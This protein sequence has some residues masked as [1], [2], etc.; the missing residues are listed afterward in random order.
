MVPKEI[1]NEMPAVL[2]VEDEPMLL[3]VVAET[4]RDAGYQ[5]WEAVNGQDA[6]AILDAQPDIVLL[7][8]DIKMPGMD[9]YQLTE[10]SLAKKPDLRVMMMTGYSQAP[11]PK[12]MADAGI[13]VLQKP[14]DIDRLP[15]RAAEVLGAPKLI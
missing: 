6:L 4:L 12:K 1:P 7:L 15:Q 8:T 10:A 5:V 14:F 11:L 9:G 3:L 2:V 13:T